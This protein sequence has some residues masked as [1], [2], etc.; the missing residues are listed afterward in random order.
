[1]L[2]PRAVLVSGVNV[3]LTMLS[4]DSLDALPPP[5]VK[6]P[7]FSGSLALLFTPELC[8]KGLWI[9]GWYVS[10][11]T[12]SVYNKWM[13]GS[14]V[15]FK[16]PLLATAFQQVCLF[17]L[18]GACMWLVPLLRPAGEGTVDGES[19]RP[20][21]RAFFRSLRIP[22]YMY[23]TQILPCA[24]LLAGDIGLSNTSFRYVTLLLYTILKLS[25]LLFVLVFSLLLGLER[26]S[27]RLVAIVAIMTGLVM[28][29]VADNHKQHKNHP[30]TENLSGG[31]LLV[32][33]AA[34]FSGLRWTFTQILLKHNPKTGNPVATMFYIAPGMCLVLVV[35]GLLF[36]DWGSL[37]DAEV[38]QTRGVPGTFVLLTVP[39]VLAFIM[40][41]CEFQLL[42]HT[43][44][45][46]LN[47]VGIFKELLTIVASAVI[48]GDRLGPVN[49]VGLV[50]TLGDICWY[51][52]HRYV[53]GKTKPADEVEM[54]EM[55]GMHGH[56]RGA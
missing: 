28:M 12:I 27:W 36:E 38:W 4:G 24:A 20:T 25:S 51:N 8:V 40:T 15:G 29:M 49:L 47:I 41:G 42:H 53:E 6:R 21:G 32:I 9:L 22:L 11:L 7:T 46:T 23:L 52:Y 1:M 50:L 56:A 2:K 55:H 34:V 43:N 17:V 14:G 18:S 16:Y 3:P 13:F 33:G 5:F 44:V 48:F 45:V 31:A 19:Q 26:F 30:E 10:L 35:F 54:D 39:G 37:P